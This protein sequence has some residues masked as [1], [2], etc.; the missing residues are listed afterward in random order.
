MHRRFL[1]DSAM[2]PKPEFGH[3]RKRETLSNKDKKDLVRILGRFDLGTPMDKLHAM[4]IKSRRFSLSKEPEHGS[5]MIISNSGYRGHHD[6]ISLIE[7]TA[8]K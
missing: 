2:V 7:L 3:V 4:L 6:K 1:K 5:I 8:S